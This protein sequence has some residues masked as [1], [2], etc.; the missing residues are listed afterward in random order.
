[1][2]VCDVDRNN[3][4]SLRIVQ[5]EITSGVTREHLGNDGASHGSSRSDKLWK[6]SVIVCGTDRSEER[7]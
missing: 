7:G 2:I 1:M 3:E 4:H 5:T 6:Q